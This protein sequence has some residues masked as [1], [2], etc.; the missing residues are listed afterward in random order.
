MTIDVQFN[1]REEGQALMEKSRNGT[2]GWI[3][4][5]KGSQVTKK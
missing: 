4:S 3:Y 2:I 5:I 1:D